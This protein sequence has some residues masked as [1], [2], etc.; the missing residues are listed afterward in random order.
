M[1][2]FRAE[3]KRLLTVTYV[4]TMI[5]HDDEDRERIRR[6]R[7]Q[8]AD[9]GFI[10]VERGRDISGILETCD[11]DATFL[12]DSVTALLSN[13]MF[14]G[15]AVVK[16]AAVK[17]AS[18]LSEL[19]EKVKNIIFV[20]DYIYS[21][22]EIYEGPTE[23]FRVGLAAVDRTLAGLCDTVLEACAGRLTAFKGEP[24]L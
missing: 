4:A 17:V 7:E 11:A 1:D 13:E 3:V 12:L 15:D 24:V 21:D 8:R 19:C 10:T 18:D 2:I 5:P 6:H 22:S 20:S 16:E 9:Y 14:Q 23:D